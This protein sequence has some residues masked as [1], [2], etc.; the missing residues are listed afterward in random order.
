MTKRSRSIL[1]LAALVASGVAPAPSWDAG[2]LA[3]QVPEADAQR[4]RRRPR[5]PAPKPAEQ[6][7]EVTP[8]PAET[9]APAAGEGEPPVIEIDPEGAP[10]V[11]V[12]PE[13]TTPEQEAAA[14]PDPAQAAASRGVSWQDVVVVMRK[15]FLKQGRLEL[16][17]SWNVTLN[18]NMIRHHAASGQLIYWL[19]DVL[20]VGAEGQYFTRFGFLPPHE[21]VA[22]A[23][24]RV[25]TINEYKWGAA[26]N[27]HYAP[28]Y[29]KFAVFN[30]FLVHWEGM[31]T[32]GVGVM[33][34][35]I[36]PRDPMFPGW[37]NTLIVPNVGFQARVFVTDW[38]TLDLG[39]RDYIFVDKFENVN[40]TTA[41]VEQ[42]MNEAS[43][44]LI[45]HI[46]F[47][48]GFSFW[49]PTSFRYTTF[50]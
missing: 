10:A 41:D 22:T 28:I 5:R 42:A 21:L 29:A 45:N 15:P 25:P 8:P 32:A 19:T 34:S 2:E 14:T 16:Q 48:A 49:I 43:T 7:V 23:Y 26:L 35:E 4:R 50:R 17:P 3:W 33:Q 27:F 39:V 44:Q 12:V 30:K 31:F 37:T 20:A 13:P 1:T 40:R 38:I 11:D 47:T 18:D 36:I 6:P 24:R 9:P 46:M